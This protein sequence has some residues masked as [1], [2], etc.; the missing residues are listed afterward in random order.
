MRLFLT[1]VF[2]SF[3]AFSRQLIEPLW[4]F[5]FSLSFL[6]QLCIRYMHIT[7]TAMGC[8]CCCK[9][10]D[11]KKA[12]YSFCY[13]FFLSYLYSV[14]S[15]TLYPP[16]LYWTGRLHKSARVLTLSLFW[17]RSDNC[18][19][20]TFRIFKHLVLLQ[21]LCWASPPRTGGSGSVFQLP[22]HQ[23]QPCVPILLCWVGH[24]ADK[25]QHS[26]LVAL[27]NCIDRYWQRTVY[28][29][30]Y[31][32]LLVNISTVYFVSV[33]MSNFSADNV[34]THSFYLLLFINNLFGV[35]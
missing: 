32:V 10:N 9:S 20:S 24:N 13:L 26:I 11:S 30:V 27:C 28:T 23:N 29:K 22:S 1:D 2:C 31:T 12:W 4:F 5:P 16:P 25:I 33:V 3:Q 18:L 17:D 6:L 8:R 34:I 19:W 7:L 15:N 14:F 21:S 35:I